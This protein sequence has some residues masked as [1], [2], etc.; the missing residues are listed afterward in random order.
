MTTKPA[1]TRSKGSFRFP[2]RPFFALRESISNGYGSVDLRHDLVAGI[3]VGAI[4]LP[5]SMSLAIAVGIPP[6]YGLYTAVV[7]GAIIALLGGSPVQVSGPTAAFVVILAPI[8]IAHGIAGLML[9]TFAAGVMLIVMSLG[10]FGKLIAFIPYPVTA[11]F[12]AGIAVV[13]ATLQIKDLFGLTIPDMPET[14]AGKV[15]ALGG[16]A[17]SARAGDSAI[18]LVTLTLLIALPRLIPRIPAPLV[19]LPI[20]ALLGIGIRTV[21]PDLEFATIDSRFGGIPRELPA[22]RL[23]WIASDTPIMGIRELIGPAFAIAVLGAIESLLSA[24]IADGMTGRKHDPDAELFAQGVGNLVAPLFGGIAAT[25]AI[26]RTATNI[27]AGGRSPIAAITHSAFVLLAMVVLAPL[28]GYLP[29]AAMAAML[30]VVAWNM[31]E[32]KHAIRVLRVADRADAIVLATCFLLTVLFDM[33][34][35]V[36]VG[37]VLAAML[38][39][40]RM[41]AMS[42]VRLIEEHH[43]L[44]PEG[45]P[46][47][48]MIYEIA[49]PLFF[50]AAQR[51]VSA[52]RQIHD[53]VKVVILDLRSV[54]VLDHTG[55]VNLESALGVL[56]RAGVTSVVAG[57]QPGP[58]NVLRKAGWHNRPD[59]VLI[60]SFDDAIA[61]VRTLAPSDLAHGGL[62]GVE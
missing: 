50:G 44:I 1:S 48:V 4:A 52:L 49:G 22:F 51:A 12:T 38:F 27:R 31:S 23:P 60:P 34:L 46:E 2:V 55:L 20:A 62:A 42:T 61:M 24:V 7:G 54:P 14:Y 6:Q 59:A 17:G 18:G 19:A 21:W 56:H 43:A 30:L 39:M 5:L 3:I 13:I 37:V 8:A 15:A 33:V 47:G 32:A 36:S 16:A 58:L 53:R 9:A 29:M 41:A 26:A 28:L 10:G 11:G 25:G 35:S 45:L 40:R 57:V